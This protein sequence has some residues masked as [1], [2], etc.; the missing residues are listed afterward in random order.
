MTIL[1]LR[2]LSCVARTSF[3]GKSSFM[4][5]IENDFKEN[6]KLSILNWFKN[7]YLPIRLLGTHTFKVSSS[8]DPE[9]TETIEASVFM[10]A[11][12]NENLDKNICFFLNELLGYGHAYSE[13]A[14]L[15]RKTLRQ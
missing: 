12:Y 15:Q 2:T 9:N 6:N 8:T 10:I 14:I 1:A 11:D 13:L 7:V 3:D 5:R 4:T